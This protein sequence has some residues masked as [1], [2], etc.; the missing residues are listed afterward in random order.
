MHIY[1]CDR[2]GLQL[3]VE[4]MTY[5]KKQVLLSPSQRFPSG[6]HAL[7]CLVSSFQEKLKFWFFSFFLNIKSPYF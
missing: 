5:P 3:I 4:L 6:K 2:W 1:L 7:C